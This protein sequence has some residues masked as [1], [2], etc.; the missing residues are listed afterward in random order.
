MTEFN[1]LPVDKSKELFNPGT[2]NAYEPER[3][4]V[5]DVRNSFGGTDRRIDQRRSVRNTETS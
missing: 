1:I 3:D 4:I 5:A 2:I